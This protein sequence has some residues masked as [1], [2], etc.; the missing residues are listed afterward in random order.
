[1]SEHLETRLEKLN[2]IWNRIAYKFKYFPSDVNRENL[3]VLIPYKEYLLLDSMAREALELKAENDH[4]R[5]RLNDDIWNDF[6]K[7]QKL[8]ET[9]RRL[10]LERYQGLLENLQQYKKDEEV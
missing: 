2:R 4:L 9:E 7:S 5:H 6:K 8:W 1:M 10:L 3:S